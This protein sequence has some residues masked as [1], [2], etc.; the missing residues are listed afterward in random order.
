[1][2]DVGS[3]S[4]RVSAR[5]G[6]VPRGDWP[7]ILER[8]L[9]ELGKTLRL[10][11]S[12]L[13][14]RLDASSS[15]LSTL[16][17]KLTVEETYF[18]RHT[19]QDQVLCQHLAGRLSRDATAILTVWSAGCATGEE[20]Y[21]LAIMLRERLPPAQLARVSI[22]A[23]DLSADAIA[24]AT[25]GVYGR[26]SFRAT[27]PQQRDRS[28]LARSNAAFELRPEIREHVTFRRLSLEDHLSLLGAGS[29]AAVLFRNVSVY[30]TPEACSRFYEGCARV[31]EPG[32]RLLIA[33]T[34]HRPPCEQFDPEDPQDSL[35]LVKRRPPAPLAQ[36]AGPPDETPPGR[37]L[38]ALPLARATSAPP[39]PRRPGSPTPRDPRAVL[40]EAR[41]LADRGEIDAARQR[42]S[43]LAEEQP[44]SAEALQLSAELHLA[45]GE[46]EAAVDALRRALSQDPSNVHAG[47]LLALSLATGGRGREA[48]RQTAVLRAQL[49]TDWA[50][51]KEC[52]DEHQADLLK[53]VAELEERFR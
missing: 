33:A 39:S 27:S 53:A 3:L 23:T 42:L 25:E 20:P 26:W 31:L 32:G 15:L 17:G 41:A 50:E 36:T 29:L 40:A 1:M 8:E 28:F 38:P 44:P 49:A 18:F 10:S 51:A 7:R 30:L 5:F 4:R 9:R 11:P 37:V 2:S 14:A 22:L 45:R 34:D 6:L 12:E 24:K 46:S 13:D 21:S 48:L 19:K 47:Y 16:A 52:L 43:A 35:T